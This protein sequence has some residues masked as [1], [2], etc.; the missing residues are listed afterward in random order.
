MGRC[1]G[2]RVGFVVGGRRPTG[3]VVRPT[4]SYAYHY[5]T[6]AKTLI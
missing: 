4:L 6:T 1:H 2:N 3:S 5:S